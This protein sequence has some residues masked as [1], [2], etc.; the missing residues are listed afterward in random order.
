MEL[1]KDLSSN[2][3]EGFEGCLKYLNDFS[4]QENEVSGADYFLANLLSGVHSFM[5]GVDE[6]NQLE[7]ERANARGVIDKLGFEESRR[8]IW[9]SLEEGRGAVLR[10]YL[11]NRS[12]KS[13]LP[14]VT[15]KLDEPSRRALGLLLHL[16][17][18]FIYPEPG[19]IL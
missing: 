5:D 9:G 16:R 8:V 1:L 4:D 15:V 19:C 3:A 6:L 7:L 2:E 18:T 13:D 10:Y 11:G 17:S 14:V 12:G